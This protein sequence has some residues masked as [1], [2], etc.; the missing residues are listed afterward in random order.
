MC[1]D[2]VTCRKLRKTS[3]YGWKV[4]YSDGC[5]GLLYHDC[6]CVATTLLINEWLTAHEGLIGDEDEYTSGYH[7]FERR[8]HAIAWMGQHPRLVVRKVEYRKAHTRGTQ[9]ILVVPGW[10][11]APTIVAKEIKILP[12][13][14]DM[15]GQR[16]R[17]LPR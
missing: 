10:E 12:L 14:T 16:K 8:R 17:L 1:L 3:G 11:N 15:S 4:F 2:K 5:D 13:T 6:Q 9:R 7:V